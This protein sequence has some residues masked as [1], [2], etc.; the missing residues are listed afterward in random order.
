MAKKFSGLGRGI[1]SIFLENTLQEGEAAG[2]RNQIRISS[3]DPKS[4]QPRKNFDPEALSQLADSIAAHGVLQP[5]L[6]REMPLGRYQIVAGERRFRAARLAGLSEIPAIVIDGDEKNAAEIAMIENIQ[7]EDLNPLEEAMG[8][9]TLAADYGM[10]QEE[11]AEKIGKSRSA[12]ANAMRLLDLPE[13][14]LSLVA[15]GELT[16]GHARAL[17]SLKKKEDMLHLAEK[18]VTS[19]LSVRDAEEAAR[20]L[21]KLAAQEEKAAHNE[22]PAKSTV[23]VDYTAELEKRLMQTLGR[24]VQISATKKK[25]CLTLYYE[26]NQDLDALLLRLCGKDFFDGV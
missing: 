1:D 11:M 18:I 24:K 2:Y 7:R 5:I 23:H 21:N 9:K 4:D 15:S 17:L 6:V 13:E 25:K 14:L 26:D 10:T 3:I 20:R 19:G 22:D 12:I 16:A 8:Y